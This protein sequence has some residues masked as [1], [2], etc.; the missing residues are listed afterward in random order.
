MVSLIIPRG[1]SEAWS[2]HIDAA[3][4]NVWYVTTMRKPVYVDWI[5]VEP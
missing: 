4:G 5:A 1:K 3:A 2:R